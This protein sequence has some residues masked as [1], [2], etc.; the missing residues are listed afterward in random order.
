MR[1]APRMHHLRSFD[2]IVGRITLRSQKTFELSQ[3]LLRSIASSAQTEVEH[4][5]FSRSAVLPEVCSMIFT[6]ALVHLHIYRG[7]IGLDWPGY[8][9]R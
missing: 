5:R 7:F 1:P 3:K 9:C 4:S 2:L 8:R 6:S